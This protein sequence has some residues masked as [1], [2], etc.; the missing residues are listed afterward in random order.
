MRNNYFVKRFP[1]LLCLLLFAALPFVA[2]GQV[3]WKESFDYVPGNLNGLGGWVNLGYDYSNPVQV[4]ADQLSYEGYAATVPAKSV[5]LVG[6]NGSQNVMTAFIGGSDAKGVTEGELFASMLVRVNA[7]PEKAVS[8]YFFSFLKATAVLHDFTAGSSPYD[9]GRVFVCPGSESG[10]FRFGI[11]YYKSNAETQTADLELGK[12]YHIVAKVAINENGDKLDNFYLYVD[13]ASATEIPAS[14][15]IGSKGSIYSCVSDDKAG[16]G[17]KGVEL[18]QKMSYGAGSFDVN[19]ADLRIADSYSAL[20]SGGSSSETPVVTASAES[21]QFGAMYTGTAV[22]RSLNVKGSNL[23]GDITISTDNAALTPSVT[24]IK[25]SDA[26]AANGTD[27]E[28]TLKPTVA[29]LTGS[30]TITL[31]SEG[32]DPVKVTATWTAVP[33][34]EMATVKQLVDA[35]AESAGVLR[36]TGKALVSYVD[37]S[38]TPYTYYI[39]DETAGIKLC[40]EEGALGTSFFRVGDALTGMVAVLS[41]SLGQNYL[42]LMGKQ[43]GLIASSHNNIVPVT[44]TLAEIAAAPKDY[45]SRVVF[46]KG[47]KLSGF[48]SGATFAEGMTQPT[49]MDASG[50]TGKLRIF[51]G[52]TLIGT[53]IPTSTVNIV[54]LST[55]ASAV[56]IGPRQAEDITVSEEE[57]PGIT[58]S[59]ESFLSVRGKVGNRT[60]IATVHVKAVGMADKVTIAP[61]YSV[62]DVFSTDVTELPAGTSETDVRIYYEP[63]A[64]GKNNGYIYFNLGSDLIAEIRINAMATD[65]STPPSLTI[66][67]AEVEPFKAEPGEEVTTTVKVTPVGMPDFINVRLE[68]EGSAF[69]IGTSLLSAKGEQDL[70]ITFRPSTA[71]T[72]EGRIVFSSEFFDEDIVLPISGTAAT[73]PVIPED[74]EGDALPLSKDNPLTEL[75]ED[76]ASVTSNKPLS[77]EGWK[78]LAMTGKR[79]WWGYTF[80]D[81]DEDNAGEFAAKVTA[82]DSSVAE[83]EESACQMMLVTPALDYL[84]S[85]TQIFAFRVMG[86]Y[87]VDDAADKLELCYIS[88]LDGDLYIEPISEVVMPAGSDEAGEWVDFEVNL[89]GLNLDDVFFLGFRFTGTRGTASAATYY[90]DDVTY[91]FPGSDDSGISSLAASSEGKVTGAEVY[92]LTGRKL[93]TAAT[94][95]AAK[96]GLPAG[97]YLLRTTT[98]TGSSVKKIVKK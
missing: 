61:S 87:L 67:P 47:A 84:N 80:P 62:Q 69:L 1:A 45:A 73:T 28:F 35:D 66:D 43:G 85:K 10:K 58:L 14:A 41:E 59:A 54:G 64:V 71:G 50:T 88:E 60:E 26:S 32:A 3:S 77:L 51:K 93:R 65:P 94:V 33:I 20:F 18:M 75:K 38:T 96:S 24:S 89:D 86:K 48:E 83:G 31:S 39:Q 74:Q 30:A 98:L 8:G 4:E 70:K 34:T 90:I 21:L 13:P 57:E 17:L 19:V 72:Y 91:G 63:T 68:Q 5:H 25:A 53:D 22:T 23:R 11:S 52:T 92:D 7:V 79:A 9:W 29:A 44:A 76:F 97:T 15:T 40:D 2:S 27:V 49:V 95:A 37:K 6:T 12:T 36:F 81:T 42:V 82:Y 16:Y 46:V 78:N 55:S 56:V